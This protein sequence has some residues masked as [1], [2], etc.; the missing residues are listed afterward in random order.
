MLDNSVTITLVAFAALA[1]AYVGYG[2][3]LARHIFRLDPRRATPAHRFEDGVDYL[4]TRVPV[5]FGHHFAS[6]A[7]LGPI[8]GP[9][10][11]VIWGWLPAV[12]WVVV[13]SIVIGAVH[14]LGAL[15]VSLRYQGRSIG[16]VARELI[17][18][19]ARFLFLL[20]IFFLMSLAMGVFVLVIS[21]LFVS[22]YPNAIVPSIGLMIVAMAMG[23]AVYKLRMPLGPLSIVGVAFLFL[24]IHLGVK[25][26]LPTYTWGMDAEA[27]AALDAARQQGQLPDPY[28]AVAVAAALEQSGNAHAAQSVSAAASTTTKTWSYLLLGYAFLASVLPVWLLLQPRDY[29]NSYQL[30]A[31]LVLLLVGLLVLHPTVAAPPV[32]DAEAIGAPPMF[33]FLFITIACGAISGFHSLV[34]SG[35]TVRQLNRETDALPIGYGAM[36]TEG[37]LAVLVIMACVAGLGGAAW[38]SG[39]TYTH[40]SN[41]DGRLSTQLAAVVEGGGR[42]LSALGVQPHYG[43]AFIAVAIV[44]F[45][46]TTLDSATRL[47]RYNVEEIF[48]SMGLGVLAN[49]FVASLVAVAGI[50]FFALLRVYDAASGAYKPAGLLLWQMFGTTNQL[51]AGLTLLCVSLFLFKLARPV[52]YTI[53]PMFA[54]LGISLLAMLINLSELW[55][56]EVR[57]WPLIVVNVVVMAMTL[58]M[59]GEAVASFA[60]GRGNLGLPET[61]PAHAD[62]EL[63]EAVATSHLG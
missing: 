28:G 57:N 61:E 14:D 52:W 53:V 6:I 58:W 3:F 48:K 60:R 50:G 16:D 30:Y 56:A 22:F 49:R 44:A 39:G 62:H 2:R 11:A 8:L 15:S 36:L 23:V 17:G 10:I 4:P 33:P 41:L 19:R 27:R 35:T 18:P 40:W 31:G 20:I 47:L 29:L 51:L 43:E 59:V 26:P 46:L 55:G 32:A 25:N 24:L 21:Q 1:A 42:F 34:S 45:A 7:G 5:L 37:A 9:A 54:M 13:G 63:E 38:T 12:L